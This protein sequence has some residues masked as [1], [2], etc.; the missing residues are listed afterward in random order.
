MNTLTV[1]GCGGHAVEIHLLTP[2]TV[3]ALCE[4][5]LTAVSSYQKGCIALL[6]RKHHYVTTY[7]RKA[8]GE[9]V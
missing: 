1:T 4:C 9:V 2:Y 6:R 5:G 7:V 3:A 8:A